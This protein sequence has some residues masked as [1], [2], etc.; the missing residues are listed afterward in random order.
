MATRPG[1][2]IPAWDKLLSAVGAGMNCAGVLT[3]RCT[4]N[5]RSLLKVGL[6]RGTRQSLYTLQ[7]TERL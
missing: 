6:G 7:Q 5:A 2:E 1:Q 4:W 3:Y